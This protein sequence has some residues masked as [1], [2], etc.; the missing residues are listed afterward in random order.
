MAERS[1]AEVEP[2]DEGELAAEPHGAVKFRDLPAAED[3][4]THREAGGPGQLVFEQILDHV[5]S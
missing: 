5:K 1:P 3:T 4:E 2:D